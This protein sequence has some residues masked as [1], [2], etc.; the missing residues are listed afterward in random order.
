[1]CSTGV[2]AKRNSTEDD[3]SSDN[4]ELTASDE[5]DKEG[6]KRNYSLGYPRIPLNRADLP[7]DIVDYKTK[8]GRNRYKR[9]CAEIKDPAVEKGKQDFLTNTNLYVDQLKKERSLLEQQHNK[10]IEQLREEKHILEY[11]VAAVNEKILEARKRG[12][13]LG[14]I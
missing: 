5:E 8:E 4:K 13:A 7:F 11:G 1:M 6:L 14:E 12:G 9:I 2:N 10:K 3:G